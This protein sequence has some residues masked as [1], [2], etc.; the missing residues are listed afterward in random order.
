MTKLK[1]FHKNEK[2]K[3]DI[4]HRGQPNQGYWEKMSHN[5]A[6]CDIFGVFTDYTTPSCTKIGEFLLFSV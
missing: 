3:N 1:H 2:I 4:Y 5:E 6:L